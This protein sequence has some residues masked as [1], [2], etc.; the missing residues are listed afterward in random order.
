MTWKQCIKAA[1]AV[2]V[3]GTLSGGLSYTFIQLSLL[4]LP[5]KD[6]CFILNSAYKLVICRGIPL[7]LRI[8]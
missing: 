4:A 6:S 3:L 2:L 5:K 1:A 8:F 7:I